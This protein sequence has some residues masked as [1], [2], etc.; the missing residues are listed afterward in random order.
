MI[1]IQTDGKIL[2]SNPAASEHAATLVNQ[3]LA[4]SRRQVMNP[5]ELELN[6]IIAEHLKMLRRVI[7]EDIQLNFFPG[8]DLYPLC[9]DRGMIEQVLM[10]LCMNARNAMS[11]GGKII[12][13]IDNLNADKDFCSIHSLTA[14]GKYILISISDTG[15]GIN[16]ETLKHIFE[17]FFSTRHDEG[18]TG[19]GLTTVYGI[20][21]QHNGMIN[22][23]SEPG[24]GS[25]F[26]VYLP[27]FEKSINGKEEPADNISARGGTETILFAEDNE[28]ICGFS[29]KI[30][31]N[32]GY[33]VFTAKDG[34]EAVTL[35]EEDPER[36]DIVILDVVMPK[37]GGYKA[38][39][40]M[41]AICPDIPVLFSSG[42]SKKAI[43]KN[44][45]NSEE[46]M[47]L[48]V[49]PYTRTTLLC[50]IRKALQD[51]C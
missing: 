31:E 37:M 14:P 29:R 8:D 4:F 27:V 48:L 36:I 25:I 20:V 51:P 42:Y 11:D 38:K 19:L 18:G 32:A 6:T 17:P 12:V 24:K 21:K 7:G 46:G 41:R 43:F 45:D 44:T 33:T 10:N 49:K 23:Y 15:C 1:A 16:N 9:A 13:E 2:F 39:K 40:L 26:K 35:F 34:L 47:P 28:N 5:Q 50:A 3:L 22:A 30:L